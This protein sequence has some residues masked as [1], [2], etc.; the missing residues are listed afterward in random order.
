MLRVGLIGWRGM[1][2]SVLMQ[3]MSEENDFAGIE[4]VFFSTSNAGG[5]A[6]A[7]A[8]RG[9]KLLDAKDLRALAGCDVLISCQGG[10]Y[11]TEVFAPL[12]KN[13]WKGHWIDAAST[14]RMHDDAIIILDPVND[15]VIR[16][17]L[18]RGVNTFA[19]GNC[20]VS[21]MLM[22]VGAL[23]QAGLVEWMT[24]MTYQAASGAGAA[25]MLE[26]VR[27]MKCLTDATGAKLSS[28]ALEVD[29][30]TIAAQ[31][32]ASL[33]VSEIGAPLAGSLIP[34]V[35]RD[36]PGGQTREEWKGMAE[37]NKIMGLKPQ[38]PV[39][40]VCVRVGTM[41]CHSQG[42][43]I[44][45][46]KDVPLAEIEK[47]IASSN[48]WV[49]VVPNDKESTLRCLTPTAVSGTLN[50]PVGRLHTLAMGPK[51]LG[52]FT[53]GDQLL[54]GAAEPLRRMLRIL[55]EARS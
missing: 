32:A 41:R 21:L 18:A 30:A 3:R 53:V 45:L 16:E 23:F 8:E 49:R 12:R 46:T 25:K 33:P 39:D 5:A 27:Q 37:T 20:T 44:K 6:P 1:V 17:G 42:L 9:T 48:E 52:A 28:D 47:I 19:G 24:T 14:L 54:W 4:P 36:M 50:V 26:L 51:Y 40:G 38:V 34:W 31:R 2:G 35:D 29:R 13:G 55:R 15:R 43:C 22:A 10:D 7:P 11:T